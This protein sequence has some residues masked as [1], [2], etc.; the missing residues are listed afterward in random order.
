MNIPEEADENCSDIVYNIIENELKINPQDIRFH[1]V[2]RFGK[3]PSRN[4]DNNSSPRP[5]A[6]IARFALREDRDLVFAVKNRLKHSRRY[7]DAYITKD[8]SRAIQEERK[9]LIQAMYVAKEQGCGAKPSTSTKKL[10][11]LPK[12][13]TI[14]VPSPLN[15]HQQKFM[16]ASFQILTWNPPSLFPDTDQ[17]FIVV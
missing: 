9:T 11:M 17:G 4:S 14:F 16:V 13:H 6:I 3:P 2:H 7:Q 12:F 10:S 5:R 15:F 8:Y 1:A